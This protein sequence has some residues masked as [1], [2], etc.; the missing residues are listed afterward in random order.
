MPRLFFSGTTSNLNGTRYLPLIHKAF[1]HRLLSLHGAY[2]RS[3]VDT[4]ESMLRTRGNTEEVEVMLDSGAFTAWTKE[5]DDIKVDDLLRTYRGFKKIYGSHFKNIWYINLDKIPGT[6]G[7]S[8]TS[9]EV[10]DALRISDENFKVL[11]EELGNN[12]IPVFHM[13]EPW[14]RVLD[15]AEMNPEYVCLSPRQGIA[16]RLR[17]EWI[18]QINQYL[19][20]KTGRIVPTHGLAT[21]GE[22]IMMTAPWR[23]VDSSSWIQQA[24]FGYIT[25]NLRGKLATGL[26]ISEDSPTRREWFKHHNTMESECHA[27]I[28]LVADYLGLTVDELRTHYGARMLFN[29]H[30]MESY[31]RESWRPVPV[32]QTLLEL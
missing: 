28:A 23:S 30:V 25:I 21:T 4:M 26:P 18:Q 1:T 16:N 14:E 32:Q 7:K 2:L 22:D 3:G 9:E 19:K 5:E 11:S 17:I 29:C 8:P 27:E 20:R 10:V 6:K 31:S 12:V 15:V 24:A 13:T